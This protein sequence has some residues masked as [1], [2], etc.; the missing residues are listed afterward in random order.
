MTANEI[1]STS[2]YAAIKA[3]GFD[4]VF[5]AY[6][7]GPTGE[8]SARQSHLSRAWHAGMLGRTDVGLGV[9]GPAGRLPA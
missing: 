5:N 9:I 2:L 6:T 7:Y 4:A 8:A 3:V 1:K